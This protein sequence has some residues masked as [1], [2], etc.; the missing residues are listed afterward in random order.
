MGGALGIIL[1]WN[2]DVMVYHKLLL[3][4]FEKALK[5][6]RR[7][8]WVPKVHEAMR[9]K[10]K[11]HKVTRQL[12]LFYLIPD[13]VLLIMAAWGLFTWVHKKSCL[14]G[15]DFWLLL[16]ALLLLLGWSIHLWLDTVRTEVQ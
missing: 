2:L 10:T 12:G 9:T 4:F 1:L 8:S 13:L 3:A 11:E 14:I 6:E 7:H 15:S 5:F 16:F